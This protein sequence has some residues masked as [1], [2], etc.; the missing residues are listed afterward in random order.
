LVS[1]QFQVEEGTYGRAAGKFS[2]VQGPGQLIHRVVGS[3]ESVEEGLPPGDDDLQR[4]SIKMLLGPEFRILHVVAAKTGHDL[5]PGL[6]RAPQELPKVAIPDLGRRGRESTEG[7]GGEVEKTD[8]FG[9]IAQFFSPLECVE[10]GGRSAGTQGAAQF[11]ALLARLR[12]N[13]GRGRQWLVGIPQF[14]SLTTL[15]LRRELVVWR[16]T[17]VR[18]AGWILTGAKIR[19]VGR[20]A[21]RR[22]SSGQSQRGSFAPSV[23]YDL[24]EF[25]HHRGGTEGLSGERVAGGPAQAKVLSGTEQRLEEGIAITFFGRN[26]AA[27]S[28]PGT[29]IQRVASSR[30]WE[31]TLTHSENVD[32][33]KGDGP[34]GKERPSNNPVSERIAALGAETSQSPTGNLDSDSSGDFDP[35][36]VHAVQRLE[37]TEDRFECAVFVP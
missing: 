10:V 32:P 25:P 19:R 35:G 6:K 23:V 5:S 7:N 37:S 28:A 22:R 29:K 14:A 17:V 11:L 33:T 34:H 12:L 31:Q 15:L 20:V 16:R 9:S 3:D 18:N 1:F 26:V 4:G 13:P 2:E 21:D 24:H 27:A 30:R 8:E 36:W